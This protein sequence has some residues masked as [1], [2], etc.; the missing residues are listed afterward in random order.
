MSICVIPA[1]GGSK[2]IPRKNIRAFYGTPIIGWSIKTALESGL[3]DHVV[4]STDD[5]EIAEVSRDL[6]AEV[7]FLRPYKLSN[8][9]AGT[10]PVIAHAIETLSISGD[11]PVCCL[12]ATAPFVQSS[13]LK[14]GLVLL[15]HGA[16]YAVSVTQYDYPIQ[17]A[18]RRA[19]DGAIAMID[20]EQLQTRS[21]DLEDTWHDAGQFYWG[22]ASSWI[23]DPAVFNSGSFGVPLPSHRVVD[24]DTPE[25]WSRAEVLFKVLHQWS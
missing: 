6:G 9:F 3:F 22:L 19:K 15:Q 10:G 23:A 25:D 7:P 8:D 18:L 12:Y 5:A 24:I 1:R 4:V 11:V 2:R 13:D 20:P 14:Q 16:R 21:Q 17:R